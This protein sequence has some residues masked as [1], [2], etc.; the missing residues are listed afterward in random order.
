MTATCPPADRRAAFALGAN[1]GDRAAALRGAV[2]ALAATNGIEVVAVSPPYETDP[3]GGPAGQSPYLNAV[4]VT[5]TRLP[6][7]ALLA[8]AHTVEDQYLRVRTR[9][10]GPRT[11]D[12][13]LLAV[14]AEVVTTP[15]LTIPHPRAHLRAFVLV[16]WADVDPGFEV[17]GHGRVADLLAEL[18][19][20]ERAGVRPAPAVGALDDDPGPA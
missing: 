10:W 15:E 7:A 16:P 1:L 6:A 12:V 2:R 3:V 17:P 8:A 20:G 18:P 4:V 11:L 19:A 5:H 9:R 14:D 13:D